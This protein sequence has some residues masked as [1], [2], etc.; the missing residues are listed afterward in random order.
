M[1]GYK[2]GI[3]WDCP[4]CSP[5]LKKHSYAQYPTQRP[6]PTTAMNTLQKPHVALVTFP[7]MGHSIPSL[8]LARLLASHT[9]AVSYVTTRSTAQRLRG[10]MDESRQ[11]ADLDI[12]LVG[13]SPPTA[14]KVCLRDAK[15]WIFYHGNL[16]P[17]SSHLSRAFKNPSNSGSKSRA[18]VD[19]CV[20]LATCSSTGLCTLLRDLELSGSFL[21]HLELL[22]PL[23]FTPSLVP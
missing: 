10:L 7:A 20:S 5:R 13:L 3:V 8:D 17:F 15:V 16:C 6:K 1:S 21:P 9:L 12:Q 2:G 18:V 4:P 14:L 23:Y 22:G 11:A 19:P